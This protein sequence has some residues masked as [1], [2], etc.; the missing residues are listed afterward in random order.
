MKKYSPILFQ[1]ILYIIQYV[2][3]P[4]FIAIYPT[5]VHRHMLIV[6]LT[7]TTVSIVGMIFFDKFKYWFLGLILYFT[8]VN[9]YH[10]TH[11]YGIAYGIFSKKL[12][13][14]GWTII[15]FII[16]FILWIIMKCIKHTKNKFIYK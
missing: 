15:V 11:I 2:I 7:T 1:T 10:P 3:L 12:S 16:E 6:C 4:K 5:D 8:M 9:L 14:I 13:I